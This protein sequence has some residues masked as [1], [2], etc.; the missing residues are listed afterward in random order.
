[1]QWRFHE[2]HREESPNRKQMAHPC[3]LLEESLMHV[4]FKMMQGEFSKTKGNIATYWGEQPL[5]GLT[6]SRSGVDRV[7]ASGQLELWE[8]T[9]WRSISGN[10]GVGRDGG[11]EVNGLDSYSLLSHSLTSWQCLHWPK[12]SE[13][14]MAKGAVGDFHEGSLLVFRAGERRL[15]RIAARARRAYPKELLS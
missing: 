15:G 14:Q 5:E 12:A 1:M 2:R 3:G 7:K 8:R 11:R 9:A 4:L 13:S 6:T 10:S